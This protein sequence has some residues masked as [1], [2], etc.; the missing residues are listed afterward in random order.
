MQLRHIVADSNCSPVIRYGGVEILEELMRF[1]EVTQG[2]KMIRG[3]AERLP[4]DLERGVQFTAIFSLHPLFEQKGCGAISA[5]IAH[6]LRISVFHR[7]S[8]GKRIV[9]VAER[10]PCRPIDLTPLGGRIDAGG[11]GSR[12]QIQS[13]LNRSL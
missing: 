9:T 13:D 11:K 6:M 5:V 1:G 3:D 4:K 8:R 12:N 2:Q 10:S 7:Y